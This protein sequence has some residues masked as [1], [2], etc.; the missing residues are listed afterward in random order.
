M[1]TFAWGIQPFR[2]RRTRELSRNH[3]S[4]VAR[5]VQWFLQS[6]AKTRR[7]RDAI[8][9]ELLFGKYRL[10]SKNDDDLRPMP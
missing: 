8:E 9:S 4:V 2:R 7:N 6:L 3:M 5:L 10:S 1:T